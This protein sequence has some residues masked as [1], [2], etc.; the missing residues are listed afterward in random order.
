MATR[1]K[2]TKQEAENEALLGHAGAQLYLTIDAGTDNKSTINSAAPRSA[3]LKFAVRAKLPERRD[4]SGGDQLM[5]ILL[6]A[7]LVGLGMLA[8]AATAV[9][10]SDVIEGPLIR[11]AVSSSDPRDLSGVWFIR[12]Y[13]RQINSTLGRLPPFTEKGKAEWDKRV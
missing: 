9:A 12:L 1:C 10:Q 4:R 6:Q 5:R 8:A 13:N 3:L 2:N 7:G 11:P